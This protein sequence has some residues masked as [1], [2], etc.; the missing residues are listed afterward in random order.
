MPR[1]AEK[2]VP[3]EPRK[4]LRAYLSL[5]PEKQEEAIEEMEQRELDAWN[6]APVEKDPQDDL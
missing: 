4:D 2:L 1:F 5:P 6:G 3:P